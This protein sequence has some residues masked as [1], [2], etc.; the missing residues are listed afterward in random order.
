MV[1]LWGDKKKAG[2]SASYRKEKKNRVSRCMGEHALA[3]LG[4]CN[5]TVAWKGGKGR[6]SGLMERCPS[7]KRFEKGRQGKGY[8]A[9]ASLV[10]RA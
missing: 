10:K 7:F 9:L 2:G 8:L 1:F 5:L 4:P 6:S 3:P